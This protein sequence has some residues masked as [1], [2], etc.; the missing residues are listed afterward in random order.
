M[1]A[2]LGVSAL[3][4]RSPS[5]PGDFLTFVAMWAST[6]GYSLPHDILLF[7]KVSRVKKKKNRE[8]EGES[9][10]RMDYTYSSTMMGRHSII[11]AIFY[12]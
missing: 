9:T 10:R 8:R 12:G 2:G 6:H 11:F 5:R 7:L 3:F 1:V 4:W